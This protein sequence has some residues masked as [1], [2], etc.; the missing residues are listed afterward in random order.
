[1]SPRA[2]TPAMPDRPCPLC[3]GNTRP[4]LPDRDELL[5]T[6]VARRLPGDGRR[7]RPHPTSVEHVH[8][9]T[10]TIACPETETP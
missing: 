9:D 1:M 8:T 2:V 10:N 5:D 6:T 7:R 4:V 3:G